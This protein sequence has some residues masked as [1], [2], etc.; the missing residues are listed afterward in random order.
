MEHPAEDDSGDGQPSLVIRSEV[1]PAAPT[2]HDRSSSLTE[3]TPQANAPQAS[4]SSIDLLAETKEGTRQ[5]SV[6]SADN[7][8]DATTELP[9]ASHEPSNAAGDY[10]HIDKATSLP[11]ES[12][13]GIPW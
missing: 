7:S 6:D 10:K 2:N 11:V 12:S 13:L 5:G 1:D 8:L 4:P 9:I 3:A